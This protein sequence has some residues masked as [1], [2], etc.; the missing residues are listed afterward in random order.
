MRV[1]PFDPEPQGD[2]IDAGRMALPSQSAAPPEPWLAEVASELRD[3]LSDTVRSAL[4][5]IGRTRG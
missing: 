5:R 3:A 4:D 2:R 1:L